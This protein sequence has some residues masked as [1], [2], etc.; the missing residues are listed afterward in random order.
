[1]QL[2]EYDSEEEGEIDWQEE[3]VLM[4]ARKYEEERMVLYKER[5]IKLL[6]EEKIADSLVEEKWLQL[7]YTDYMISNKGRI[8]S[9]RDGS[10]VKP[11]TYTGKD[12]YLFTITDNNDER[13]VIL[14][15]KAI[16]E[17]FAINVMYLHLIRE[18]R[19]VSE[20]VKSELMFID[21]DKHNCNANN[22]VYF[23]EDF[24]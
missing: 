16:A 7:Y 24:F 14:L 10:M 4:K 13:K 23:A 1:M 11:Y 2:Y 15:K 17:H 20:P 12:D 8:S 21:G 3:V 5:T 9:I 22:L 18:K 6:N 19:P